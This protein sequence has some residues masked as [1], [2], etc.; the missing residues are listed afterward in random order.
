MGSKTIVKFYI[1][2]IPKRFQILLS[3]GPSLDVK[4]EGPLL[5]KLDAV[6]VSQDELN[7]EN[8]QEDI[9]D[10]VCEVRQ[11]MFR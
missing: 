11:P 3:L 6:I 1:D 10:V 5:K 8:I 9:G 2:C 7:M 4:I